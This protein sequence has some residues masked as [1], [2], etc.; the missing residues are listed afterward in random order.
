MLNN[1]E[2]ERA[3]HQMTKEDIA[4][5][6]GVTAKTYYNWITEKTDV[7]S[8]ALIKMGQMFDVTIDYLLSGAEGAIA[9]EDVV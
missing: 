1:I 8:S 4:K 7:P 5:A 6:F 9:R 2:A 3:R